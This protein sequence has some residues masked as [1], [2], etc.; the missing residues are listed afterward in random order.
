[1]N[2]QPNERPEGTEDERNGKGRAERGGA[3]R[4]QPELPS[5]M[6]D[7]EPMDK[8]LL[9]L[10]MAMGVYS[11]AMLALRAWM[12]THPL[13]Y[14][15][16]IGGYT[17]AT[18]SGANV[19]VGNGQWWMYLGASLV[20]A[21]KFVP[22]YWL[23]GKRWGMEFIE[24]SLQYMPRAHRFFRKAIKQEASRTRAIT[25]GL[26]PLG[27]APGPVPGTVLNAVA[28]LLK[29]GF[30]LVMALNIAS[31]LALNGLFMWLGYTF[32]DPVLEVVNLVNRYMLWVT[33]GLLAIVIIR[34]RK[35]TA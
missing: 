23:M 1:M 26:L 8:V 14:S 32:G 30:G 33:L 31:V 2:Q 16:L 22:V 28:G 20:G 25:L 6:K 7:P 18:V 5:F 12:L 24:M 27:Y 9:G 15:F 13:A 4:E 11:M 10:L 3:D 21:L 35:K 34:A 19:S 17:S 29:V